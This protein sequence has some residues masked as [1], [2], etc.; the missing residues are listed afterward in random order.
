[1]HHLLV[2]RLYEKQQTFERAPNWSVFLTRYNVPIFRLLEDMKP[3][4][5]L[6]SHIVQIKF[7]LKTYQSIYKRSSKLSRFQQL[8]VY[9]S[10]RGVL[11]QNMMEFSNSLTKWWVVSTNRYWIYL[12]TSHLKDS[13]SIEWTKDFLPIYHGEYCAMESVSV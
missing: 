10:R 7:M 9:A 3:A 12:P 13:L 1:M 8:K 5:L 6:L 2:I 11:S 4:M